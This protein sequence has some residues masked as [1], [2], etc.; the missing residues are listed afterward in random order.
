MPSLFQ[1]DMRTPLFLALSAYITTAASAQPRITQVSPH[2]DIP[3][4]AVEF[5]DIDGDGFVDIFSGGGGGF[6]HPVF[7]RNLGDRN[8]GAVVHPYYPVFSDPAGFYHGNGKA[9]EADGPND[10]RI[11]ISSVRPLENNTYT[12]A[13][14]WISMLPGGSFGDRNP[15]PLP[16]DRSWTA[17]EIDGDHRSEFLNIRNNNDGTSTLTIIEIL[18]DGSYSPTDVTLDASISMDEILIAD[19]DDDDDLDLAIQGED[20]NGNDGYF[21]V[22]RTGARTFAPEVTFLPTYN[23]IRIGDLDGDGLP[24]LFSD[25]LENFEWSRNSGSFAFGGFQSAAA[26]PTALRTYKLLSIEP[27]EEENA[28]FHIAEG[29]G[30]A[31]SVKT[32]RFGT[33]A[34]VSE[35]EIRTSALVPAPFQPSYGSNGPDCVPLALVDLDNDGHLDLP[36]LVYQQLPGDYS[37]GLRR[38]AIAWGIPDGFSDPVYTH[39]DPIS[40]QTVVVG[41][42]DD[43]SAPDIIAG[44][45]LSGAHWFLPNSGNGEFGTP[46]RV[47]ALDI[48]STYP[49]GTK[50]TSIIAAD[51]TGDGILDLVLSFTRYF[52]GYNQGAYGVARGLG[53]GTFSAPQLP[54]GSFDTVS[55]LIHRIDELVDWDGDGDLDIISNGGWRENLDGSFSLEFRP[56]IDGA[57]LTDLLGNPDFTVHTRT[58]DVDGDGHPDIISLIYRLIDS[59]NPLGGIVG[60]PHRESTVAVAFN[61]GHGGI[62]EIAEIPITLQATDVLGNPVAFDLRVADLNSDGRPDLCYNQTAGMDILGNPLTSSKWRRN[63]GGAA[64]RNPS[65]W[66]TLPLGSGNLPKTVDP[67]LDFDGDGRKDWPSAR[68]YIRPSASGPVVSANYD[69]TGGVYFHSSYPNQYIADFDGDGDIDEL[70][71]NEAFNYSIV[72]NTLVDERSPIIRHLVAAGS[73]GQKA[74]PKADADGDGRDNETELIFGTDPLSA[75]FAPANALG[76]QF[77]TSAETR[78]LSFRVPDYADQLALGYEIEHSVDLSHWT[79]L[80]GASPAMLSSQGGWNYLNLPLECPGPC[81]YFRIRG[82][83]TPGR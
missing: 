14:A 69:F 17:L 12:T 22:R 55:T 16:D 43:Q 51:V 5:A 72:H 59:D 31:L 57:P 81:G 75:D 36:F 21:L 4:Y 61:D 35:Q 70:A 53:D 49:A 63:P 20:A 62:E 29:D 25:N 68:G 82:T 27:Q 3:G 33:W 28:L 67:E 79:P 78:S 48:P 41:N 8:F 42:F 38:L 47:T 7:I 80:T 19:L 65:L 71:T 52:N 9:L 56:L 10:Y 32:I 2:P 45:D 76:V 54:A 46:S 34:V 26:I 77:N 64:A 83:H 39:S 66:I 13:H 30:P 18:N 37:P 73:T 58:G 44:P 60:I 23:T 24:E 40:S 11:F 15:I 50:I 1:P 74:Q 6:E